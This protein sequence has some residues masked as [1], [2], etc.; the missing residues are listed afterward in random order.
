MKEAYILCN[1]QAERTAVLTGGCYIVD[2]RG[3]KR[4]AK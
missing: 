2:I 4:V 1:N 3:L